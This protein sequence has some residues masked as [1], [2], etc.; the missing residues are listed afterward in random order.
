MALTPAGLYRVKLIGELHGQATETAFHFMT[1]NP[2]S[3]TS[4]K[5]ELQ[6]TMD[7]FM[8]A[9]LPKFQ[10][11]CNQEWSA[12]TLIGVT[13]IPKL[14]A[15]IEMRISG[16]SGFQTDNSLPSFCAGV[17]SL[18][19]GFGGRSAIGRIYVPGI[20]ENLSST[21]R[22][23]GSYLSLLANIGAA[24]VNTYGPSGSWPYTR[25]GVFSRK[26][27][28]TRTLS[29]NPTLTYSAA[30]FKVVTGTVARPEIATMRRRKLAR[31]I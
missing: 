27:G 12:K 24:L 13:L 22:L 1:N 8:T 28:V 29:P 18:R 20:S 2:T 19:S 11:F 21:S 6:R 10:A 17:L 31:G 26:I 23:E 7:T 9:I 3:E 25:Y 5:V 4:Y 16:G 15:F 30:G 14:E